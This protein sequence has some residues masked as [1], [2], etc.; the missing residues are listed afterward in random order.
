VDN[1][2]SNEPVIVFK[3]I[4]DFEL[5]CRYIRNNETKDAFIL[6][7]EIYSE[8]IDQFKINPFI[9]T[10]YSYYLI[11]MEEKKIKIN[12]QEIEADYENSEI[13]DSE[14]EQNNVN[15]ETL[16]S[17]S[18][19]NKENLDKIEEELNNDDYEYLLRKAISSKLNPWGKYFVKFLIFNLREKQHEN[20]DYYESSD[21][22]NFNFDKL[23]K[24][25]SYLK[26]ETFNIYQE[27]IEKYPDEKGA[28]QL[29]GLFLKDVIESYLELNS[30]NKITKGN[31]E[32][33]LLGST[34]SLGISKSVKSSTV[35]DNES[36]RKKL[37]K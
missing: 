19:Q 4:N 20:I 33:K 10:Y 1:R 9:F 35:G 11:Y 6:M 17:E 26:H 2:V 16:D 7:K 25:L 18:E 5:A 34:A 14:S 36:K 29:Y 37:L 27:I 23:F 31:S 8:C 24:N 3:N 21:S 13:L 32:N 28:Y 30:P 12:N 15:Q 22:K